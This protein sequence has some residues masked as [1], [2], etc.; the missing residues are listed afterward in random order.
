M[1]FLIIGLGSMGKR[2]IR[3][4]KTLGFDDIIGYDINEKRAADAAKEYSIEIC[5][6]DVSRVI[7]E[8]VIDGVIISTSPD[9]HVKYID[10]CIEK[11]VSCFIEASVTDIEGL[12]RAK[13]NSDEINIS[14]CPS[15]TMK[16]YNGPKKL[17]ELIVRD[18]VIGEC[19]YFS[20]VTG[21]Y[22]PDWHPWEDIND[23][24]VSK[25]ETGGGRELVPFE[26]VWLNNVFGN[27]KV[28][29]SVKRKLSDMKADIDDFYNF[30]LEY[31]NVVGNITIEV[32]SRPIATR[33]F[34]AIGTT[35]IIEY[36]GNSNKINI[37]SCGKEAREIK[38]E[39][40]NAHANYINPE[41]PYI[42]EIED[43]INT[44]KDSNSIAFPSSLSED[45][46]VLELLETIEKNAK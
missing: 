19:M 2:R 32:L 28:V 12:K 1:R 5:D 3:C 16:Y 15:C 44:I 43:F 36:C 41:E 7:G 18:K 24:Y 14:I 40:G 23:Y 25:R 6:S 17:K 39:E 46:S 8:Q 20:Y 4:L 29:N 34:M 42:L 26:M 9:Q 21:Q 38:L 13:K 35:G 45:I 37:N 27:P 30:T 31:N 10:I 11:R 22:L 33:K